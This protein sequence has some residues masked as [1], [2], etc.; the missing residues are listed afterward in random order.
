MRERDDF[1]KLLLREG[2]P[3]LELRIEFRLEVEIEGRVQKRARGG[4]PQ[5]ILTD[6]L[7]GAAEQRALRL[8][9]RAPHVPAVNHAGR[10][11]STLRPFRQQAIELS[12][13]P[14]EIYVQTLDGQRQRGRNVVVQS[15]EIRRNQELSLAGTFGKFR[16]RVQVGRALRFAAVQ[17]EAW[18]VQLDP[19]RTRGGQRAQCLGVYR[20]QRVE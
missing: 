10:Q 20:Q 8:E 18:L 5:S 16:V 14:D 13:C 19:R 4:D 1:L 6:R 11:R 3:A 17:R 9:V 7:R 12:W 2:E 15:R